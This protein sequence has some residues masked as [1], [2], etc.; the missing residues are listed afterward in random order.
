MVRNKLFTIINVFGMSASLACCLLLLLYATNELTYDR[1]HGTGVYR[2]NSS[3]SQKDGE[4]LRV[5]S[6]SIPISHA[7]KSEVPEVLNSGRATSSD[8]FGGKNVIS[9][10]DDSW[11]IEKGYIVDTS[12]FEILK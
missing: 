10:N 3:I 11:Y 6:S 7:I 4:M 8:L 1:H 5:A 2:L 12:L 9:H